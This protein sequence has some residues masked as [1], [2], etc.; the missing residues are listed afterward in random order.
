MYGKKVFATLVAFV[1]LFGLTGCGGGGGGGNGGLSIHEYDYFPELNIPTVKVKHDIQRIY[2]DINEAND[3]VNDFKAKGPY[4]VYSNLT[5]RT[6]PMN[7]RGPIVK[8][9]MLPLYLIDYCDISTGIEING[10]DTITRDDDLFEV[11]FGDTNAPISAVYVTKE[12]SGGQTAQFEAYGNSL[13]GFQRS[14]NVWMKRDGIK[15][16]SWTY[17]ANPGYNSVAIWSIIKEY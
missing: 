14:G 1:C 2:R 16:L 13:S 7:D 3:F 10:T 17:G 4:S 5:T 12:Y 15:I 9:T 6:D 8:A 11:I